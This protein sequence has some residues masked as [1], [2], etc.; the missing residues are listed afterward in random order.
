MMVLKNATILVIDDDKNAVKEKLPLEVLTMG[1]G[2]ALGGGMKIA[3]MVL[4]AVADSHKMAIASAKQNEESVKSARKFLLTKARAFSSV[5]FLTVPS[6]RQSSEIS[7][8]LYFRL[9]HM[10]SPD[11]YFP[12]KKMPLPRICKTFGCMRSTGRLS[13]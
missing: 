10:L 2:A 9:D 3:H 5:K 12:S 4:K 1:G 6:G 11:A 8:T 7:V 13:P